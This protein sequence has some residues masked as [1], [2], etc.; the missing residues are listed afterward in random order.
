METVGRFPAADF[1]TVDTTGA[2]DAFAAALAVCLT[3]GLDMRE[4]I[5]R[6]TVAAGFSTTKW[7]V[8][9]AMIDWDTTGVLMLRAKINTS[10]IFQGKCH[11]KIFGNVF[12]SC[13]S[14]HNCW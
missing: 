14:F 2:A 12:S 3:K 7:G 1:E 6:A 10:L 5:H 8:T 4:A 11:E 9:D 13:P